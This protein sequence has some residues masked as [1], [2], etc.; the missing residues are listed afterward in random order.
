[1]TFGRERTSTLRLRRQTRG[2]TGFKTHAVAL[3]IPS[4]V[5]DV[6]IDLPDGVK[7][8]F[9]KQDIVNEFNHTITTTSSVSP[10][11]NYWIGEDASDGSTLFGFICTV[12]GSIH[13]SLV[14]LSDA[15][16][17]QFRV[18]CLNAFK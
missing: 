10:D 13:G 15:T 12:D 4:G 5:T 14:D 17:S 2:T 9:K 1:M 8:R 18:I 16:I 3:D 6:D 7:C 11:T